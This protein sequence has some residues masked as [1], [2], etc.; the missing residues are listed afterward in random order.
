MIKGEGAYLGEAGFLHVSKVTTR[1]TAHVHVESPDVTEHA[2][3]CLKYHGVVPVFGVQCS[4]RSSMLFTLHGIGTRK[5][6]G[7]GTRAN[8]F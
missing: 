7:N 8:G 4:E 6:T 3:I 2:Q 5:G 1:E